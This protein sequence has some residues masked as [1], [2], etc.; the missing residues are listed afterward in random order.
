MAEP[1]EVETGQ[2]RSKKQKRKERIARR[3]EEA[4]LEVPTPIIMPRQKER[5]LESVRKGPRKRRENGEAVSQD[6]AQD[7]E[8]TALP[9][10]VAAPVA[11]KSTDSGLDPR[12]STKLMV[13]SS[14]QPAR[15]KTRGPGKATLEALKLRNEAW[16]ELGPI[17]PSENQEILTERWWSRSDL[18]QMKSD[19]GEVIS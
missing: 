7:S 1:A 17:K 9:S 8:G 13:G 19:R 11:S 14:A 3:M 6:R 5:E 15:K 10:S 2:K 18:A 16:I 12:G 4:Q